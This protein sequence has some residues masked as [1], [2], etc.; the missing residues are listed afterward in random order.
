[1]SVSDYHTYILRYDTS[2]NSYIIPLIIIDLDDSYYSTYS[3]CFSSK[4]FNQTFKMSDSDDDPLVTKPFKFVTGEY[5]AVM[6]VTVLAN[7]KTRFQ[8][9]SSSGYQTLPATFNSWQRISRT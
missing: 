5:F 4:T 2:T 3:Q 8:L 7:L 1:M 6:L 9:V